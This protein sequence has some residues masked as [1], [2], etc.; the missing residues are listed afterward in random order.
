MSLFMFLA[1]GAVALFTAATV[2]SWSEAR[3]AE[4]KARERL[5]LLRKLSEQPAES[6]RLVMDFLR[7]EDQREEEAKRRRAQVGRKGALFA[8]SIVIAVGTGLAIMLM[9]LV[10]DRPAWTIGLIPGLVGV[11]ILLFG[12]FDKPSDSAGGTAFTP[13]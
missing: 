10:P 12:L 13:K 7:E 9:A 3:L 8:G 5:A 1:V 6:A 4:R 11:V 2:G